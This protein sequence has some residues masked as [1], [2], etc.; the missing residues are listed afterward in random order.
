MST[1]VGLKE[2]NEIFKVKVE[3]KIYSFYTNT[4]PDYMKIGDTYRQVAI[5]L[6][7]W[8]RVYKDL[9]PNQIFDAHINNEAFFRDLAVHQYLRNDKQK[10][11]VTPEEVDGITAFCTELFGQDVCTEDIIEAID[12]IKNNYGK[13]DSK[14]VY[15][16]LEGGGTTDGSVK[17]TENYPMRPN[18]EKTVANFI[19][20]VEDGRNN[21]LM[22]AVMRFGKS[23]TA[24]QC[25]KA[26][27]KNHSL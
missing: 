10:H 5:R 6:N 27:A 26:Y 17:W 12:D 3:H 20:A 23:F 22:Y 18:Q 11:I 9:R 15:Y 7:E 1:E 16:K 14:Y 25:A 19:K 24:M 2:V 4:I 8:R 21:L 13:A